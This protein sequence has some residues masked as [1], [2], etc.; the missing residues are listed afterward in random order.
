VISHQRPLSNMYD[1]LSLTNS[2]L[3]TVD[4]ILLCKKKILYL[5]HDS[6]STF[7]RKMYINLLGSV[8]LLSHLT[9]STPTKSNLYFNIYFETVVS[10]PALYRLLIF[11]VPNLMSIFLSLGR[12]SKE[13]AQVRGPLCHFVRSL[14]FTVRSCYFHAQ[15][16]S[17]RTTSCRLPATAYSIYLQLPSISGGR[18]LHPQ[19]EDPP[20][21]FYRIPTWV[22]ITIVMVYIYRIMYSN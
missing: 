22:I 18:L 1:I 9:P 20:C 15:L 13:S 11:H 2:T 4:T 5:I 12:L 7:H 16:P 8:S 14:F 19:A 3:L 6:H 21:R 17:R 10:E